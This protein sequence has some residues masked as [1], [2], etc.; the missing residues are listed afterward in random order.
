MNGA[1]RP[2]PLPPGRLGCVCTVCTLRLLRDRLR[3]LCGLLL[4]RGGELAHSDGLLRD[5]LLLAAHL[6]PK[7]FHLVFEAGYE[8]AAYGAY[9]RVLYIVYPAGIPFVQVDVN[10]GRR[11]LCRAPGSHG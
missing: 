8:R 2:S 6:V 5:Y 3:V 11:L 10:C 9:P 7:E 4:R 1:V